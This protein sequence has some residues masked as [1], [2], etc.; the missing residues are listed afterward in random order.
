MKKHQNSGLF[1]VFLLV[2]MKN[3]T[4]TAED[5]RK[6]KPTEGAKKLLLLFYAFFAAFGEKRGCSVVL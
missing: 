5:R 4:R 2:P 6:T 3:Q 1:R